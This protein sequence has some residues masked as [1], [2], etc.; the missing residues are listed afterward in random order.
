MPLL[1]KWALSRGTMGRKFAEVNNRLLILGVHLKSEGYP[2]VL[3][4][5][6]DL[7]N[8]HAFDITEINQPMWRSLATPRGTIGAGLQNAIRAVWVHLTVLYQ[9]LRAPP[10]RWVYVPYPAVFLLFLLGLLPHRLRP[11]WIVVD[12]FISIYDT[13]V[14]D[15][16]LLAA[17]GL[18]ARLL[19]WVERQAYR[20]A[21]KIVVD[22]PQNADYLC[23][24]FDL[25]AARV[26]SIPLSTNETAFFP[27]TRAAHPEFCNVLFVGTLIPLHG[28]AY[29]VDAMTR[30]SHRRD[31][32]F[33]I[34]GDGQD[35]AK[36][37]AALAHPDIQ[38]TWTRSWQS[39]AQLAAE[40]G[41]ADICLGIFGEGAKTQRVC[42]FKI[43]AYT[44]MGRAT[45]TGDTRW[46]S[47]SGH[48]AA[49]ALVP[50]G[51]GARLALAI[52]N[53]VD[54]PDTRATLAIAGRGFYQAHLGNQI[55]LS[56][57]LQCFT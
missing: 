31:I 34:I 36:V 3:Y 54:H 22:T 28:I 35:S 24:I 40:I 7:T 20:V 37:A 23:E 10:A 52:E 19:H 17:R 2:N 57:I 14:H 45:I 33:K 11:R 12:A 26:V 18:S 5:L 27:V 4:R 42:P 43:Y 32:R 47:A 29:I 9:Y 41:Q 38:L 21:D 50:V 39:S 48:A 56:K 8:T 13:V 30:L 51:D 44:A 6:Q 46:V 15:R 25:P 16:Q 1:E 49:F 53:L 55:A